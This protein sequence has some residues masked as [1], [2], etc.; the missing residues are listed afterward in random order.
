[1]KC[2]RTPH[3]SQRKKKGTEWTSKLFTLYVHQFGQKLDDIL[4][5]MVIMAILILIATTP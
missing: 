2:F 5:N 4:I 3:A 1:M